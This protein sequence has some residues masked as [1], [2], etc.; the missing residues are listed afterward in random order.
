[1]EITKMKHPRH[2]GSANDVGLGE[3]ARISKVIGDLDRVV[4]ILDCDVATEEEL[5]RVLDPFKI[6][7]PVLA[8]ALTARR[9][10]LKQTIAALER[11]LRRSK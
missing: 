9:D 6:N 4:R 2:F 8:R 5:A 10:N 7:Y 11:R 3:A 1:M